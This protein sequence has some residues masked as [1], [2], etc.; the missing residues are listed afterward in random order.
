MK[1]DG[2]PIYPVNRPSRYVNERSEMVGNMTV[3]TGDLVGGFQSD[4]MTLRDYFAAAA[5]SGALAHPGA[6]ISYGLREV[7]K[8]C[9]A[10]A[11]AMLAERDK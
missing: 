1:P 4:G 8:R 11:D 5:M 6:D 2:G 9:Y 7:A 10:M 3:K